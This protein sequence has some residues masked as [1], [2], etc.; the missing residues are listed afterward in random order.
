MA[1]AKKSPLLKLEPIIDYLRTWEEKYQGRSPADRPFRATIST[2]QYL[3]LPPWV[4]CMLTTLYSGSSRYQCFKIYAKDE[5]QA[6][7]RFN[8]LWDGLPKKE[9]EDA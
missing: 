3:K 7:M 2:H 5:L 1:K 9:K 4:R 6:M 8:A